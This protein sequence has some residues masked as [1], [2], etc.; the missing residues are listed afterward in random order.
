MEQ[1]TLACTELCGEAGG[2]IIV[3]FRKLWTPH[4][5][6]CS[7][8]P[9]PSVWELT[10]SPKEPEVLKLGPPH[11]GQRS[12]AI[13]LVY[14]P[15]PSTLP[16]CQVNVSLSLFSPQIFNGCCLVL[17]LLYW[18][19]RSHRKSAS[20]PHPPHILQPPALSQVAIPFPPDASLS[21]AQVGSRPLLYHQFSSLESFLSAHKQGVTSPILK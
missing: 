3:D 14:S 2:S 7:S 5:K 6:P 12:S 18:E 16:L 10:A 15:G 19:G 17:I 8:P 13:C 11:S 1:Q 9:I 4:G 20:T 21:S